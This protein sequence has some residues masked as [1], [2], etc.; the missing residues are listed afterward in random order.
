MSEEPVFFD[1]PEEF[2]SWLEANHESQAELFVG[3]YRKGTG[4]Q[5]MSWSESVDQALCFGW[6]DSQMKPID[7]ERYKQRFTPRKP[8]ST[9]S[10]VNVA[11][12]EELTRKGLMRPAGLRAFE[13]RSQDRTGTYSHEQASAELP[14]EYEARLRADSEAS[15]F[16]ASR[17][18]SYRRAA[19]WWVIS[20]KREETRERR[21]VALIEDS[22]AGRTVKHLSRPQRSAAGKG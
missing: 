18:A 11:K 5:K 14:P 15:A 2:T 21:L 8:G 10:K 1:G 6:I 13:Q 7:D 16:F 3:F 9:W 19:T 22:R 4:K 20:A 17:P 12:V